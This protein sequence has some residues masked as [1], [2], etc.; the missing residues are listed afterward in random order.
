MTAPTVTDTTVSLKV[1][2]NTVTLLTKQDLERALSHNRELFDLIMGKG[3]SYIEC[4]RIEEKK[5]KEI[6]SIEE[7]KRLMGD[8]LNARN[9]LVKYV[10]AVGTALYTATSAITNK[11][12]KDWD[13]ILGSL[14]ADLKALEGFTN[15]SD[16]CHV[17]KSILKEKGYSIQNFALRLNRPIEDIVN[18]LEHGHCKPMLFKQAFMYFDLDHESYYQRTTGHTFPPNR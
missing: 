6:K 7:A 10:D 8:F 4:L 3:Y 11:A 5:R 1:H 18:F 15:S 14:S 16:A 13:T 9:E 12:T 17:I 2:S